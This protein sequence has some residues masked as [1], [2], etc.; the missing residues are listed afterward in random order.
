MSLIFLIHVILYI[1]NI[2]KYI[3]TSWYT[4]SE[5]KISL[6]ASNLLPR[7]IF[8]FFLS[9]WSYLTCK[10]DLIFMNLFLLFIQKV[11]C[12]KISS[13]VDF[14][15]VIWTTNLKK[16]SGLHKNKQGFC[17]CFVLCIFKTRQ[18]SANNAPS[19]FRWDRRFNAFGNQFNWYAI[20]N[21]QQFV[22]GFVCTRKI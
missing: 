15:V 21:K 4:T 6:K 3:P 22:P 9:L 10:I 13:S 7:F 5:K 19:S 12:R 1:K 17:K 2:D 14:D 8:S 16:P 11:L 20:Q 18:I